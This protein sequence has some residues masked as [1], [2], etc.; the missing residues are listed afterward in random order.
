[1]Q[2]LKKKA[3]KAIRLCV[4]NELS[5]EPVIVAPRGFEMTVGK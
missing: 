4:F 5:D 1:M 2:D 3:A